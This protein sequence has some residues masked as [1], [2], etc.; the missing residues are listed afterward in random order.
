M[1]KAQRKFSFS[2]CNPFTMQKSQFI[3][4][5]LDIVESSTKGGHV[6]LSNG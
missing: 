2:R 5:I 4:N 3:K 6:T 1:T